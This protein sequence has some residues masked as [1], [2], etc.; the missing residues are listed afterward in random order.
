LRLPH[1]APV[2]A[3]VDELSD[4]GGRGWVIPVYHTSS[5]AFIGTPEVRAQRMA[6]LAGAFAR[7]AQMLQEATPPDGA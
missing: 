3:L 4:P 7:P 6:D 1:I 2:N 5:Q